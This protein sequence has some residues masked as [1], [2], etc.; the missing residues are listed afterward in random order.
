MLSAYI[1]LSLIVFVFNYVI[2]FIY[3]MIIFDNVKYRISFIIFNIILAIILAIINVL[4]VPYLFI[5]GLILYGLILGIFNLKLLKVIFFTLFLHYVNTALLLLI[6]GCFLYDGILLISIPFVSIFILLE[7][8]YFTILHLLFSALIKYF[9]YKNFIIHCSIT[10]DNK[11]FKGKGYYD[12]GNSLLYNELP[13]IFFK[14]KPFNNNGEIIKI[15]GIND[16][17][18]SYLAYKGTYSHKNLKK[19]VYIVFV[20]ENMDFNNCQF[21]LNKYVI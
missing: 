1:D 6:G 21:L 5:F 12:S 4:Y 14:G 19:E 3:S 18:F 11:T 16:Y 20:K 2:S 9:K 17:S 13:V 10:L 8:I 15:K 7:P